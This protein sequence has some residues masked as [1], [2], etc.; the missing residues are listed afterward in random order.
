MK[1]SRTDG[2]RRQKEEKVVIAVYINTIL[3]D[4]SKST[5]RNRL[6]NSE[7]TEKTGERAEKRNRELCDGKFG[8]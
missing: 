8:C 5:N 6:K 3:M 2:I 7:Q 1:L 4:A